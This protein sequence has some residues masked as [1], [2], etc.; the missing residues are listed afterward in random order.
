MIKESLELIAEYLLKIFRATF[1][2]R[3]YSNRWQIWD[4]IMLCKPGKPRYNIPKAHQPIALMNTLGKLLSVIVAEDLSF[5]CEHYALLP[6][7]HFGGRP[8]VIST[9]ECYPVKVDKRRRLL[10]VQVETPSSSEGHSFL[11]WVQGWYSR[12]WLL[13]D[14]NS[15]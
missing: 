5:M 12:P 1:T 13:S 14:R 11:L 8:G 3:T 10:G 15:E 7:N 9:K 4:T 2:L 6:D